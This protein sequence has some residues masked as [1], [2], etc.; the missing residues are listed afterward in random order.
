LRLKEESLSLPGESD[1]RKLTEYR[2]VRLAWCTC[3]AAAGG[4][5]DLLGI[6]APEKM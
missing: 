5:L 1:Y 2:K 3:A 4:A 6:E